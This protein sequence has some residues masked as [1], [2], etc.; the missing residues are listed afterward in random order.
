MTSIP[1]LERL[2]LSRKVRED[3]VGTKD[4]FENGGEDGEH[5]VVRGGVKADAER[6]GVKVAVVG[7]KAEGRVGQRAVG[8]GNSA[9]E[10]RLEDVE[11]ECNRVGG[12]SWKV[13]EA[14]LCFGDA[15]PKGGRSLLRRA[16]K[17]ASTACC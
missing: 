12:S 14:K 5:G 15:A 4:R 11:R 9:S 1:L 10:R 16:V 17:E 8:A 7:E 13:K 2:S 3:T 6:A